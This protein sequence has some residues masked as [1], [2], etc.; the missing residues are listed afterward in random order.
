MEVVVQAGS[1]EP[2]TALTNDDKVT[3]AFNPEDM[4]LKHDSFPEQPSV[5]ISAD[6]VG[7]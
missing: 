1:I 2:E 7:N 5:N 4:D 6:D 3:L